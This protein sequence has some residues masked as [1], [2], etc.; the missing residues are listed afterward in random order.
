MTIL[1]YYIDPKTYV[2]ITDKFIGVIELFNML[3]K[4]SPSIKD[5]DKTMSNDVDAIKSELAAIKKKVCINDGC[6]KTVSGH[7]DILSMTL[8]T[9]K[10]N[11]LS[12]IHCNDEGFESVSKAFT[13]AF[14]LAIKSYDLDV[15]AQTVPVSPDELH[16]TAK[17]NDFV[18]LD[19]SIHIPEPGM[20]DESIDNYGNN[21]WIEFNLDLYNDSAMVSQ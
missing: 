16:C 5:F 19:V 8:G 15:F 20:E 14:D 4:D 21:L 13:D 9:V 3:I 11:M 12:K 18:T 1:H 6:E 10:I 7:I 2:E 17:V